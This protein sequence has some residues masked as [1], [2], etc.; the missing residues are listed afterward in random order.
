MMETSVLP[1]PVGAA[2][3]VAP[4]PMP[5]GASGGFAPVEVPGEPAPPEPRRRSDRLLVFLL[6]LLA[7]AVAGVLGFVFFGAQMGGAQVTD[8]GRRQAPGVERSAVE[9]LKEPEAPQAAAAYVVPSQAAD[10]NAQLASDANAPDANAPDANASDAVAPAMAVTQTE[11]SA[12]TPAEAQLT[13]TE[14][15]VEAA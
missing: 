8:E 14:T 13:P 12:V 11:A 2:R 15:P 1:A 9:S 6:V 3:A 7:L 5:E 10:A 4:V